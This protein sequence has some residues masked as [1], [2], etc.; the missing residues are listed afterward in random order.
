MII[1][2]AFLLIT[3]SVNGQHTSHNLYKAALTQR[4]Y[5]QASVSFHLIPKVSQC[6]SIFLPHFL[7]FLFW[8]TSLWYEICAPQGYNAASSGNTLQTFRGQ[9]GGSLKSR[10]GLW[11]NFR[12]CL[13]VCPYFAHQNSFSIA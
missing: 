4:G 10:L 9:R 7:S 13:R 3:A 11:Y 2:S 1:L 12:W 8:K 6:L 5:I